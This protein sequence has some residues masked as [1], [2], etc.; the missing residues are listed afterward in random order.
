MQWTHH[1]R[2]VIAHISLGKITASL[3]LYAK[4]KF[5]LNSR[6]RDILGDS[7]VSVARVIPSAGREKGREKLVIRKGLLISAAKR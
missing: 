4:Y 5:Y 7:R 2:H 3:P 1:S 6:G